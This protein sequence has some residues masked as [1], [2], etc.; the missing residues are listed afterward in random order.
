MSRKPL[1]QLIQDEPYR[2]EFFQA[3]RLLEKLYPERKPVGGSALPLQEVVRFRF[4]RARW[5]R[6]LGWLSSALAGAACLVLAA[7]RRRAPWNRLLRAPAG[8]RA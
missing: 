2:F 1:N 4:H 5:D 7:R 8:G 3:V 6:A